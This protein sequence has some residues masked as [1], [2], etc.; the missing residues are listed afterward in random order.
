MVYVASRTKHNLLLTKK[1]EKK[2]KTKHN[3]YDEQFIK[4][5]KGHVLIEALAS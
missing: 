4:C 5:C 3:Q 2:K 1:K